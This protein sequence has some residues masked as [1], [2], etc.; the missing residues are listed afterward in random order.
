MKALRRRLENS[1]LLVLI[2][3]ALAHAYLRLCQV[4]TRWEADG[5]SEL[6]AA[7]KDGPIVLV[8]WHERTLMGPLHWPSDAALSS[9]HDTS[10]IGRVSGDLQRRCGLRPIP[11]SSTAS[12]RA[13]SREVLRR[14][15]EG[16]SVALTGDGPL[17]PARLIKS[18]PLDW[19]RAAGVPVFAYAFATR[20]HRQLDSWDRMRLPLPFTRGSYVYQVWKTDVPRRVSAEE[21]ARLEAELAGALNAVCDRADSLAGA[22]PRD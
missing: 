13:A 5:L 18:A 6:R 3:S 16:V 2:I 4:T 9:L 12:N 21:Q 7:L 10:P 22:G 20:R 14:L 15:K 19:A 17:G 1:R 8:L 11:M